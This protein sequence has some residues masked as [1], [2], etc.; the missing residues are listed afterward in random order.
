MIFSK[1]LQK[2]V[3]TKKRVR[4][5]KFFVATKFVSFWQILLKNFAKFL[6]LSKIVKKYFKK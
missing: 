2:F 6:I 5:D 4:Y 1:K 3:P